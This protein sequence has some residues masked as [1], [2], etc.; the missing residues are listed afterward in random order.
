MRSAA[1]AIRNL[2]CAGARAR[3]ARGGALLVA[4]IAFGA[5][6]SRPGASSGAAYDLS[7]IRFGSERAVVLSRW[8]VRGE[9]QRFGLGIAR[10]DAPR[11]IEL[12]AEG[13]EVAAGSRR[14]RARVLAVRRSQSIVLGPKDL[15]KV[16]GDGPRVAAPGSGSLAALRGTELRLR[17]DGAGALARERELPSFEMENEAQRE[18]LAP[19]DLRVLPCPERAVVGE[20]A[21]EQSA[22]WRLPAQGGTLELRWRCAALPPTSPALLRLAA[23]VEAAWWRE[24]SAREGQATRRGHGTATWEIDLERRRFRGFE[25]L[26]DGVLE[27]DAGSD[28]DVQ[29]SARLQVELRWQPADWEPTDRDARAARAAR[30]TARAL[31]RVFLDTFVRR[32]HRTA[33]GGREGG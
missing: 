26:L 7:D 25:L 6:C 16:G 13:E 1:S 10:V 5:G 32:E 8:V 27:P 4:A 30:S 21:S 14:W 23:P 29:A 19:F 18:L 11:E 17:S 33:R 31:V 24:G 22:V 28:P 20:Q 9:V 15:L 2:V 3:A 12:V